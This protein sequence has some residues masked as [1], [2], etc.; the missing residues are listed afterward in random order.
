MVLGS[1]GFAA[2]QDDVSGR[3]G[4]DPSACDEFTGEARGECGSALAR[5]HAD[6]QITNETAQA[7]LDLVAGC[8]ASSAGVTLVRVSPP[9][10][11][12]S[13]AIRTARRSASA[14]PRRLGVSA[15]LQPSV[16]IAEARGLVARAIHPEPTAASLLSQHRRLA[17]V[18][19][20]ASPGAKPR[21][22]RRR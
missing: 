13:A 3:T 21:R 22:P 20:A 12:S 16:P 6:E 19:A 7:A 11:R 17:M 15:A 2:D 10:P 8:V 14:C 4:I 18:A 5:A 9:R 1:V